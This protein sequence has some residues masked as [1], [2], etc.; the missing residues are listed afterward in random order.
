MEETEDLGCLGLSVNDLMAS[1]LLGS[2]IASGGPGSFSNLA[3]SF[4]GSA[5]ATTA[6][7]GVGNVKGQSS[8]TGG[9]GG[10]CEDFCNGGAGGSAGASTTVI[11]AGGTA[12]AAAEMAADLL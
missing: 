11:A 9:S 3:A 6:L 7:A 4:G 12:A 5:V 2:T 10:F 1:Y 8:A